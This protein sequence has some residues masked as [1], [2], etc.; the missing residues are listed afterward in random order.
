MYKSRC[1]SKVFSHIVRRSISEQYLY[2]FT[3]LLSL[4]NI[5]LPIFHEETTKKKKHFNE[6]DIAYMKTSVGLTNDSD[7]VHSDFIEQNLGIAIPYLIIILLCTLSGCVGNIMVIG[8]V[9]CY[10]VFFRFWP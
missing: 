10:K 5:I 8:C 6:M 7:F 4:L 2:S 3:E 9:L 1:H